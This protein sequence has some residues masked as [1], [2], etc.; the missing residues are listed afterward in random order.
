MENRMSGRHTLLLWYLL[1]AESLRIRSLRLLYV[2]LQPVGLA[3][4]RLISVK[5]VDEQYRSLWHKCFGL[6]FL[7]LLR[8]GCD[9]ACLIERG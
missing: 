9:L 5:D 2:I 8:L 1:L 3:M 4:A 7:H 6:R